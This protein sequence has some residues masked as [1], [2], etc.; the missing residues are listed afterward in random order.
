MHAFSYWTQGQKQLATTFFQI[1]VYLDK[2][3][4]LEGKGFRLKLH[5][6]HPGAP[7]SPFYLNLRTVDHPTAPGPLQPEHV[8]A[9]GRELYDLAQRRN[10]S[11]A[12]VAG[13]PHAGDPFA[14]ALA[15][16]AR[17]A[18]KTVNVLQLKKSDDGHSRRVTEVTGRFLPGDRVLLVDDVI[19]A[20]DSKLEAIQKVTAKGLAVT[21]VLVAVDREQG[22]ADEMLRRGVP[23]AALFSLSA[24]L[25]YYVV[26]GCITLAARDEVLAYLHANNERYLQ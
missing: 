26:N 20:A 4:S 25:P 19:T 17:S 2:Q 7:L 5:E 21:G 15:A 22:G 23:F 18:G 9:I 8:D 10:F 24:L 11:F 13:I 12:H 6:K 1:G 16:T 14:K 3:Q